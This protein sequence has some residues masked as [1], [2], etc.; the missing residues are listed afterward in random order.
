[1]KGISREHKSYIYDGTGY[2]TAI[3]RAPYRFSIAR[4]DGGVRVFGGSHLQSVLFELAGRAC[5]GLDEFTALTQFIAPVSEFLSRLDIAVDV[6]TDTLPSAFVNVRS[7]KAF[8]SISYIKSDSGET[9]YIGSNKSDRFARVY[10]YAEPHPRA[11]LLRIE[12][13]FRRQLAKD[14]AALLLASED[15]SSFTSAAG[16]TW[17]WAHPDWQP[18][19][20]V[21]EKLRVPVVTRDQDGTVNWLYT[22]VAPAMRRLIRTGALDLS[23]FMTFVYEGD[24]S[25]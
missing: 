20:P 7:H 6:R 18:D 13:V 2:D 1:M 12:Y 9:C 14:T 24:V 3:G 16:N 5:S 10:R 22:Q 17:G 23:D 15:F 21:D 11:G 8:R 25:G 4:A 19:H